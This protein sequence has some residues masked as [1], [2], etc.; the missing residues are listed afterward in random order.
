MSA[1]TLVVLPT[2]N[3]AENVAKVVAG[4]R[5]HGYD[6][7][8]VDDASP[9]GTGEIACGLA[10]TDSAV[11]VLLRPAKM[12]LG[13]AYIDGFTQGMERGYRLFVEMDA[14]GSHLP[15]HLDA[16]VAGAR[17]T[18]GLCIGSRYVKGGAIVGWGPARHLL[19]WAANVYC[20]ALLG[21][22]VRDFTSGFRCYTRESLER[23]DLQ[24]V[25][26]QGY[27]FQIEMV[28]RCAKLGLPVVETPIKFEDRV[29]GR[30]KVSE[31][32]VRKALWT[33][34]RLRFGRWR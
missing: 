13:S 10:D 26:S 11:R 17:T 23:I 16:I 18:G 30:S 15:E 21:L 24:R 33:V 9:D 29:L 32:E 6:V 19:S 4:V 25:V 12:G 22:N 3:E 20:R 8:V 1:D 14:D 28:F 34:V 7:L 2:F 27:S 5:E 31:G